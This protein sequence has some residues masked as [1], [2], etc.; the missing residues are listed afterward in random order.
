MRNVYKLY[1]IYLFVSAPFRFFSQC[2]GLEPILFLGNDSVYCATPSLT[3]IAPAGYT[4]YNWSDNTTNQTLNVTAAGTYSVEIGIPSGNLVTNGSFELGNVGFTTDYIVGASGAGPWGPL[5]NPGSYGVST[6]PSLLHNN[7]SSCTDHTSAPGTKMLVVNGAG[8]P[9]SLVWSQTI[10]VTAA[11]D[12]LFGAWVMNALNEPNVG[13]LQFFINGVAIGPT[14][15]S[16]PTACIWTQFTDSWNSG[17]STS[18]VLKIVNQ[19]S[20]NSGND[21]ALDDITFSPLCKKTD[22]I[23]IGVSAPPT[24]TTSVTSPT[25]CTGPPDGSITITS[26]TGT[27]YSFDGGGTWQTSNVKSGLPS[28][29][30][31]VMTKN[32]A[33]CTVTSI[34]TLTSALTAPTQTTSFTSPTPCAGIPDGSI[35]ITSATGV[36]FSFNGGTTWQTANISTGLSGGTY[37]VMS[38]NV[39][40]CTVSSVVTL[41]S[42]P[43]S[44]TQTTSS[45]AP[46]LCAGVPDGAITIICATAVQYSFDGGSTWQTANVKSGLLPGTYTVM[47]KDAAGCSVSSIVVLTGF[48]TPPVISVSSDVVICQNGVAFLSASATGGTSFMYH[49]DDFSG[50][51]SSQV[52][53]PTVSGY[54]SVEVENQS[55]CVST[56]DSILVTVL[57]PLSASITAPTVVCPNQ[58]VNLSVFGVSG[59]LSPYTFTWSIGSTIISTASSI[60]ATVANSTSYTVEVSDGCEST[61]I[62]LSTAINVTPFVLPPFQ[63]DLNVQCEPAVFNLVNTMAPAEVQSSVW[64]ISS[65]ENFSNQNSI[66]LVDYLP[67]VYDVALAVV[68]VSGCTDTIVLLNALTVYPKPHADFTFNPTVI[69]SLNPVVNFVNQSTGGISYTWNIEN[70]APA[71]SVT[72]NCTST[73]PEGQAGSYNVI[74]SAESEHNCIDSI[75]K[76]VTVIEEQLVYI[77]NTFTPNEDNKNSTWKFYVSGYD[78]LRSFELIVFNRWGEIV[79]KTNEVT[80]EWDGTYKGSVVSDGVYTWTLVTKDVIS[81]NK[82]YFKGN[83]NILR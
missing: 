4:Y 72:D 6:S 70:G 22:T 49:W 52:A 1:F 11:T 28:G 48:S 21:F 45:V 64:Q 65:G 29:V 62:V 34:V 37:T 30:Y 76:V 51:A 26:A 33:G 23:I 36:Q 79:W 44:I 5:S 18:A 35:T 67:G 12:Y 71:I 2:T 83:V 20:I 24:Q 9:N 77:P 66:Q 68:S 69:T 58:L 59:G 43:S 46:S 47:S 78:L 60:I 82:T 50:T 39:E 57:A 3:L 19:N 14:F 80:A 25:T 31:T 55:G 75:L 7:F 42:I 10:T 13:I 32:A 27:Q 41:T 8:T 81:D 54:Y 53:S 74:L 40:G 15:S 56:K 16:G 73:F 63:I 38:Q 61:P 17:G